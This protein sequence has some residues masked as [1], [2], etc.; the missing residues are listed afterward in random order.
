[1]QT[2]LMKE[3]I[4][5][6]YFFNELKKKV[7]ASNARLLLNSAVIQSG[8]NFAPDQELKKEEAQS[9]CMELIRIG[10]PG[11]QVGRYIYSNVIKQ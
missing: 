2:E 7:S 1:M 11:F 5:V 3:P 6:N 10:G 4:T 8:L 9:L